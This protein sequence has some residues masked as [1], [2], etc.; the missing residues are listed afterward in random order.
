MPDRNAP[1]RREADHRRAQR[2][3]DQRDSWT[4]GDAAKPNPNAVVRKSQRS[5]GSD[6]KHG[7]RGR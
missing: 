4:G 6:S 2:G 5:D 3:K 7:K 1:G